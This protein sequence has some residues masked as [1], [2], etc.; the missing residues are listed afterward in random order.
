MM[1][2]Y[3]ANGGSVLMYGLVFVVLLQCC[4]VYVSGQG[5]LVMHI[6]DNSEV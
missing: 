1:T 6:L 3:T 5:K 4:A 2:V